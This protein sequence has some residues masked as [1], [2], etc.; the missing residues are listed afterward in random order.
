MIEPIP[1]SPPHDLAVTA[2]L[3]RRFTLRHWRQAPGQSALL[4]L[5]LALGVAVYFSIRLANRAAVASFQHFTALVTA[6]SDR[7]I[8]APAGDLPEA[9]LG[10]LRRALD[11]APVSLI[12]VVESTATRPPTGDAETIGSRPTFQVLGL[13]LLGVQNLA[14]RE[15]PQA[16]WFQGGAE[17][18]GDDAFGRRFG[19]PRA[20]FLS[21][22]LA[23][24]DGLRPGDTLELV[25]NERIVALEVAGVIP[26]QPGR[27]AAPATLL[28]MDLPALQA[29]VGRE[30]RLTRVEFVVEAGPEGAARRAAL[31]ELLEREA[32]G[33]WLVSTPEERS[34][35]GAMMTRAFRLNLTI[36]SLLALLVGLYLIVQALDGA[37]VRRREEIAVLRSLGVTEGTIR[38]AWLAEAACLGLLGGLLGAALGWAGAQFTVRA[39]GRTVNALYYATSAETAALAPAELLAAVALAVAAGV[40]AGWWPARQAAR[41]PPAQLLVRH[42]AQAP[43]AWA[44]RHPGLGAGL[45]ALGWACAQL[46]PLRF[47]GGVRFPLGGYVTALL[48][49]V[50][51]GILGGWALAWLARALWPLGRHAATARLAVSHL[52]APS[53]RHVL[54]TAGLICAVA[55]TAGM[56]ILVGSFDRTMHGWIGRTF[57]ADLFI[58]SAGAQ[59]AS[60]DNR[61]SPATWR[62]LVA[63]PAVADANV[64]HAAEVTLPGG[65]TVLAGGRFEFMERHVGLAWVQ[66]PEGGISNLQSQIPNAHPVLASESFSERFS[67][68]RGDR[69][70]LPTPAGPQAVAIAGVFA[71]YGNERGSLVVE[72]RHFTNWFATEHAASV[73][74][75]L[76]DPATAEAVRAEFLAAHPGLQV[77]TNAHLRAEVLRI[78]RQTFAI[79]YAL[80]AIG[81]TVAVLGLA[82]TLTSLLLARRAEQT[83]L[84]ALG[85][86]RR[87]LARVAGL[88]GLV[89]AGC[90]L[91][92]GLAASLALGWLLI[93][94][95]NKQT[96]GWTLEFA[97][98]A[99]PLALLGAL[100]V[101]AALAVSLAVGRWGAQLPAER[102]E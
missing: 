91:A 69:L 31:G 51:G 26:D 93:R 5:I 70:A 21:A 40:L 13:D 55:M 53:G 32:R 59:S 23:A 27:P 62:T 100:V 74:L 94:V 47:E 7:V 4:V 9:V 52:T 71:D 16:G 78:F 102:E 28:V 12:P 60:T 3:L 2:L 19:N 68:R 90:G 25:L 48:W 24:R 50:G 92:V 89:V 79:T 35:A 17:E 49:I 81:L 98:P 15:A 73:I 56:V 80:E 84:R 95:I 43:A 61:L 97:L 38:R 11:G 42:A 96:F 14:D 64:L 88:E 39:V 8:A 10:E 65:T 22:A 85:F 63:H 18:G 41:T 20:V 54:A 86:T 1:A 75:K 30:G 33:R 87:E 37:V 76:H 66:A 45:L 67:L 36:L 82:M 34:A 72:A 46:P 6:A 77:F 83:T 58:S 101:A 99:G 29:L 44:L 57:Q